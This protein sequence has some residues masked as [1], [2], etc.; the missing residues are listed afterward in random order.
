[1]NWIIALIVFAAV[2]A[3]LF[4]CFASWCLTLKVNGKCPLCALKKIAKPRS[5]TI[6][7]TNEEDYNSGVA[8]TPPMG[9]SSWNTFRNHID[10]DLIYETA[11]AMKNSGLA[12]AGYQYINLDD[13]W[14]SSQRDENGMLQGDMRTFSRGIPALIKDINELGLKVG[15]YSS[16][17]SLTCEDMPASLGNEVLDAKTIAS[18]GCEFFKYDFCHSQIIS[19]DCPAVECLELN[20]V[21][22][23][24]YTV[25]SPEDAEFTGRAKIVKI[26]SLPTGK[27]IGFLNHGAGTATFKI[28]NIK[29]GEYSITIVHQKVFRRRDSYIQVIVNGTVY[30]V[31]IPRG[32]GFSDNGRTQVKVTLTEGNNTITIQNPVVTVADSSYI[33]YKRMGDALKSASKQWAECTHTEEKPIVFSICE[34]GTAKPWE[35]GRKAGNMWRTTHDILPNWVS[36]MALYNITVDKYKYS[37]AGGW[38]DPDMLEV[39]NGKLTEEENKAHFSLWCMMAAPLM[40]GNDIRKFVDGSNNAVEGIPTLKIV[41]N[42]QLIAIDQDPLGKSAMRIKKSISLDILARPLANG[43]AAICF[44]NKSSSMKTVNYDLSNLTKYDYLDFSNASS[45]EIHDLWEDSRSS[46]TSISASIAKHG[47]KVYRIKAQH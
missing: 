28:N 39:G 42:R 31:F 15:L 13:C 36:I 29:G 18:W 34:W 16:N 37:V 21:G 6:D 44:L 3:I 23:E 22:D 47:V 10:Q 30:E 41:T 14:Q 46:G 5:I 45:F 24:E 9:W 33:Q 38:N 2:I 12:D 35:W 20:R 19:G 4:V 11:Q 27:A 25:L 17:G 40:L 8:M 32:K 7:V 1:M 26:P 43:D